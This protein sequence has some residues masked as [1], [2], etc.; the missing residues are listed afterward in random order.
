MWTTY[1]FFWNMT[2][3]FLVIDSRRSRTMQWSRKFGNLLP[4]DQAG[5]YRRNRNYLITIIFSPKCYVINGGKDSIPVDNV[6]LWTAVRT[7]VARKGFSSVEE[8]KTIT[9]LLKRPQLLWTHRRLAWPEAEDCSSDRP[10]FLQNIPSSAAAV[11]F[12]TVRGVAT[13]LS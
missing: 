11:L 8:F 7:F 9:T 6:L 1:P 5:S 10:E 4:S 12:G 2:P 3:R 13:L